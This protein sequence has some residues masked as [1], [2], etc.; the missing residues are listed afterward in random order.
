MTLANNKNLSEFDLQCLHTDLIQWIQFC[1]NHDGEL[2]AEIIQQTYLKIV[3]GRAKYEKKS[4]LRTWLFG[5]ARFTSLEV[6]RERKTHS[7]EE[8]ET[9]IVPAS[10]EESDLVVSIDHYSKLAIEAA[11]EELSLTQ[12]EV[13]YLHFYKDFTLSEIAEV[14]GLTIGT[15]RTQYHRA[16]I[17]LNSL[18]TDW[19]SEC[20]TN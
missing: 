2:S 13:I 10:D 1:T 16:K 4:A 6:L 18:L 14:L 8:L 17:K 12:R 3:E 7:G 9:E 15:V 19:R 20:Q 11:I 5:V